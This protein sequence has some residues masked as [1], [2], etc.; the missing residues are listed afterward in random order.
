[1]IAGSGFTLTPTGV[2]LLRN[3]VSTT[4]TTIDRM[5]EAMYTVTVAT[6]E[7]SEAINKLSW[8]EIWKAWWNY[9][10]RLTASKSPRAKRPSERAALY[11]EAPTDYG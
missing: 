2:D 7:V 11:T 5:S 4:S 8:D 1:M 9:V 6:R 3:A 10:K